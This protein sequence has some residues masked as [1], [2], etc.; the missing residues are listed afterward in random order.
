MTSNETPAEIRR[1]AIGARAAWI[2]VGVAL[3]AG[4]AYLAI[5]SYLWNP[6]SWP[7]VPILVALGAFFLWNGITRTFWPAR[8]RNVG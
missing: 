4:G 1:R 5:G 3:L 2:V 8:L 6:S 7:L